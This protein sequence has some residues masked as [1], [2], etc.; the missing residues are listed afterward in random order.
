MAKSGGGGAGRKFGAFVAG[1]RA[2]GLC[3]CGLPRF[4]KKP[5]ALTRNE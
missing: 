1:D 2:R 5:A 3:A 4:K